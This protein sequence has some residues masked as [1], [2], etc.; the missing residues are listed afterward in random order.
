MEGYSFE[1]MSRTA[2]SVAFSAVLLS[3]MKQVS[4]GAVQ[5]LTG[6][7]LLCISYI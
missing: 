4:G 5:C 3:E 7:D 2:L 6:Y 1:K